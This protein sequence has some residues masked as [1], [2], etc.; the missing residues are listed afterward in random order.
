[1]LAGITLIGSVFSSQGEIMI[2]NN[3]SLQNT[4]QASIVLRFTRSARA[5][6]L[7][8]AGTKADR[9]VRYIHSPS[10]WYLSFV[11]FGAYW[12]HLKKGIFSSAVVASLVFRFRLFPCVSVGFYLIDFLSTN[13]LRKRGFFVNN[14]KLQDVR[15][16]LN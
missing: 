6:S 10:D 12:L 2:Y 9:S 11:L 5:R 8:C 3:K 7:H 4:K 15:S 1:M 14:R 16:I 13:L